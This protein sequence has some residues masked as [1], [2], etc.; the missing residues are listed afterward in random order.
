MKERKIVDSNI[1]TARER[2]R[3]RS[4]MATWGVGGTW[5]VEWLPSQVMNGMMEDE[6]NRRRTQSL[7]SFL[8]KL[9]AIIKYWDR[10][11]LSMMTVNDVCLLQKGRTFRKIWEWT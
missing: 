6:N 10:G 5:G 1:L 4:A 9:V 7:W 2:S 11:S 8:L 3:S